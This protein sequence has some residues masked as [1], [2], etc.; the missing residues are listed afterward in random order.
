ME[1]TTCYH[2]AQSLAGHSGDAAIVIHEDSF[3]TTADSNEVMALSNYTMF[4]LCINRSITCKRDLG[5]TRKNS[6]GVLIE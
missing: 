1:R 4:A 3:T 6:D 5:P 2:V